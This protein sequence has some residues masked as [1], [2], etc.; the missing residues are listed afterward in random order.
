M[1]F[2]VRRSTTLSLLNVTS[3]QCKENR[4]IRKAKHGSITMTLKIKS[5]QIVVHLCPDSSFFITRLTAYTWIILF[6]HISMSS[7]VCSVCVRLW[8]VLTRNSFTHILIPLPSPIIIT[9]QLLIDHQFINNTS[10]VS[11]HLHVHGN[12]IS[13]NKINLKQA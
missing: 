6:V 1:I 8:E 4:L 13:F 2:L 5:S 3:S 12:Q 11:K 10:R 9:E 7:L